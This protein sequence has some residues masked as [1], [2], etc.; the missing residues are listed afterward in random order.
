L[1]ATCIDLLASDPNN[2]T[3]VLNTTSFRATGAIKQ[4]NYGNGL[5]LTM[6]YN[7]NRQQPLSMRVGLP[8]GTGTVLDYSYEY[9]TPAPDNKNNNRL[10]KVID[11]LDSAYTVEYHYD[12]WNRLTQAQAGSTY[13]RQYQYDPFGNLKSVGGS[14]GPSAAFY[15][16]NYALNATGAPATNRL[17]NADGT[18]QFGHDAAGNLT[19]SGGATFAYD[20]AGR[21]ASVNGGASGQYG[22]DGDS[23]RVKK[24]EGGQTT[25]YVRSSRGGVAFEVTG[26]VVQQAY[27]YAGGKLIAQQSSD[28]QFY[29]WHQ[30][31]LGSTR[32]MTNTSGGV[33]YTAQL[34]P[35]GIPLAEA[36]NA[37][38]T[39]R[40][41]AGHERDATGLD[42]MQAR[43]YTRGRGRFLQPDPAGLSAAKPHRPQSLNRYSYV[44][45]DP[46]NFIDPTGTGDIS[47]LSTKFPCI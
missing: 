15:T 40:K 45:N 4:L 8:N 12:Q 7:V 42:N 37:A 3:N 34:D 9:Y 19:S 29:W 25:Y 31:H 47:S 13:Q 41:F 32:A 5:Q 36:G 21:M 28:G 24:V 27:V 44:Q 10:R 23:A 20:G 11:N 35:H 38:L 30:N 14:G 18:W 39:T 33:V 16:L 43:M 26:T 22:Y 17:L 2:T 6:G 46:V 1:S